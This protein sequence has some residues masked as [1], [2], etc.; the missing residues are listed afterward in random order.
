MKQSAIWLS[1]VVAYSATARSAAATDPVYIWLEPP[2]EVQ[3]REATKLL[4][5]VG[6]PKA[7]EIW[8]SKQEAR[9][10]YTVKQSGGFRAALECDELPIRVVVNRG[11]LESATYEETLGMCKRGT[12]VSSSRFSWEVLTPDRLFQLVAELAGS[13]DKPS[14]CLRVAFH[15]EMGLPISINF[16]CQLVIDEEWFVEVGGLKEL[17]N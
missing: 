1:I 12:P 10:T 6:L 8:H 14:S 3:A 17:G 7:R 9:V 5:K 15:P 2:S 11:Q 4:L 13:E 16:N